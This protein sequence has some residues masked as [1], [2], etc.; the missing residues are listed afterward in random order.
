[1]ASEVIPEEFET[2]VEIFTRVL[3]T[4]LVPRDVIVQFTEKVRADGYRMLR[5]VSIGDSPLADLK[6]YAPDLE[7]S[8]FRVK[9]SSAV[10]G[11]SLAETDLRKLHGL[12]VLAIRRNSELL[13]N[14]AG[15]TCLA[16]GDVVIVLGAREKIASA[17]AL[18]GA[19]EEKLGM[20]LRDE[21]QTY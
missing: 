14:P 16:G 17:A 11:K 15:E 9:P 21:T 19:E 1:G 6:K 7:I 2:S 4:F 13:A 8:V 18:F 5:S 3:A 12:S 10:A 20:N